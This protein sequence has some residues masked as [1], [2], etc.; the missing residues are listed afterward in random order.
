MPEI[1]IWGRLSSSNVQAALWC[2]AELELEFERIDAGLMYGVVDT[3]DYAR[4]NPNR[5]I[6]TLI[7]GDQQPLFETG[8]ILRY[9]AAR[10]GDDRFWPDDIMARAQ[11]DKW[12]EW[13]KINTVDKFTWPI[14]WK[15]V[16]TAPSKREPALIAANLEILNRYLAIADERLAHHAFLAG[17]DFT[18]ADIQF[19][20]VL[21]RYFDIDLERSDFPYM[22]RYYDDLAKRPAFQ[23]YVMASYAE[24]AVTD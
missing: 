5:T 22:R 14:F 6:P 18:L 12:A 16:R 24:L 10:Y 23:R 17:E 20:H 11:I 19:G 21:Y 2:L 3:P 7:D 13:A 15:V 1:K 9:L 4:M 8:A